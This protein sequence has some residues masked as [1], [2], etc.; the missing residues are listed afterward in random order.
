MAKIFINYRRKDSAPYAGRLYDRLVNHFGRD[1]VFIDIDQ[2]ELGKEF[3]KVIRE[4]LAAVQAAVVLIGTHWLDIDNANQQRRLDDPGDW[5]RL[6]ID[7]LLKRD[8]HVIPV[9]VGGAAM[10]QSTQL[11]ECLASLTRRN[12]LEISDHRFHTDADKLIK[13]LEKIMD[14][15]ASRQPE[16]PKIPDKSEKPSFWSLVIVGVLGIIL[17]VAGPYFVRMLK[18]TP[19]Q[20]ELEDPVI[21]PIVATPT[22]E[23]K[24]ISSNKQSQQ[25]T[26]APITQPVTESPNVAVIEPEMVNIPAGRFWMGSYYGNSEQPVREVSISRPFAVSRYEIT[27][28]EFR[29]FVQNKTH[30]TS[31]E[32]N[33]RGCHV[34]NFKKI[35]RAY[36]TESNWRNPRFPQADNQP[37]VCVSWNDAQAY[38]QWLSEQ[39]GKNYRLPTEA[40]WEYAARAD[41]Q[42]NYWWGDDIGKNNAVCW[43]CGSRWDGKQTAPVGSFRSN[44]F[45]LNDTAGNIWEWTQDC[46]HD[47]Y[48]NAPIDGH[49]A[50]LEKDSGD[51]DRRVVRG[52]GWINNAQLLHSAYR[53]KYLAD[54]A[55]NIVGFRIVRDR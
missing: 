17:M 38:A 39:T 20:P 44:A 24:S 13:A 32:R 30:V 54:D 10:P 45:G 55:F 4:K 1:H 21:E 2:I 34:Y 5:V 3:D 7:E 27:V 19:I 11:P 14:V 15:P 46:W 35:E 42:T 29:Q 48:S 43:D 8:I 26:S 40:E 23:T 6:E 12:A 37:V 16:L 28:S 53:T 47:Y 9:L 22:T 31:A 51:C 18:P 33:G 49:F 41:M 25:A 36:Q 50:W 52:G